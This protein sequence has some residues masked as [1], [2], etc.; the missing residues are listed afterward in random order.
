[1]IK[2][3]MWYKVKLMI[4]HYHISCLFSTLLG[5]LSIKSSSLKSIL[6]GKFIFV[7][8]WKCY[9]YRGQTY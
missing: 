3:A 9:L 5:G 4:F 7:A 2:I 6:E 8:A 1:M